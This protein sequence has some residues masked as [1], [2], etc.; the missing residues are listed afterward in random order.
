[1]S[2]WARH[3]TVCSPWPKASTAGG[4]T[5]QSAANAASVIASLKRKPVRQ[6]RQHLLGCAPVPANKSLG[7]ARSAGKL[8]VHHKMRYQRQIALSPGTKQSSGAK[9]AA[10]E[11][12]ARC[13]YRRHQCALCARRSRDADAQCPNPPSPLR[14]SSSLV[15]ALGDYLASSIPSARASGHR[16]RGSRHRLVRSAS[17][18]LPGPLP[19][20]GALPH[21]WGSTRRQLLN[22]FAALAHVASL[23]CW[24]RPPSDRRRRAGRARRQGGAWTGTGLGVAGLVWSG[25]ELDRRAG[26]GRSCR[27]SAPMIERQLALLERL[28]KG[29]AHLSAERA[30]VRAGLAELYQA[31]AAS[32]GLSPKGSFSRTT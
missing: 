2:A 16:R 3:S 20:R 27:R 26:R 9:H 4:A 10:L 7:P 22:D 28:R 24:R 1:M 19:R 6:R 21:D 15:A 11:T 18:T 14:R 12:G 32:H 13:R 29:R 23:S 8:A 30:A 5:K 25:D 17:P 31:M